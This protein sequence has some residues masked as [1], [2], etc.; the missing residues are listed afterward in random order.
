MAAEDHVSDIRTSSAVIEGAGSGAGPSSSDAGQEL[1]VTRAELSRR[2]SERAS[3]TLKADTS[4]F[5]GEL[6]ISPERAAT[7]C[8]A[9]EQ[10]KS[11][12]IE[13]VQETEA[14]QPSGWWLL[15]YW[16]RS[17]QQM[18][19]FRNP[20]SNSIFGRQLTRDEL[21][22]E[23]ASLW[24]V[25]EHPFNLLYAETALFG[26][27]ALRARRVTT[28]QSILEDVRFA[29]STPIALSY[30]MRG[31]MRFV[32]GAAF[33]LYLIPFLAI[34]VIP[35]LAK[36][37]QGNEPVHLADP[38]L[39]RVAL[40]AAFGCLGGVVSVLMRLS[41]F[42]ATKGR[43]KQFLLLSGSTLPLVGGIFAAVIASLL[44]SKIINFGASGNEHFS[45]WLFVVIGFL[46]G[47][48]ERFTRNILHVAEGQFSPPS[49]R[50]AK[51]HISSG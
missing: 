50:T 43:S 49:G 38:D 23:Y 30:V 11:I 12:L 34:S 3:I 17:Q 28:A 20:F 6:V 24:P 2:L 37:V 46:A 45:I 27:L 25:L 8:G 1:A 19:R 9:L 42:E 33:I 31:V 15:R 13:L 22:A 18:G 10:S 7:L 39:A 4:S 36:S 5:A 21:V 47:F 41:E 44:L 40:A 51:S 35:I 32:T 14:A 26:L 16:I 29:T 48:S